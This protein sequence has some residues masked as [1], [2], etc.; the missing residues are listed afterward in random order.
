[1]LYSNKS[2]TQCLRWMATPLNLAFSYTSCNSLRSLPEASE[3]VLL[4]GLMKAFC[5]GEIGSF[6]GIGDAGSKVAGL[7]K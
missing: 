1:M 3:L 5:T 7:R 4:E 6:S 2:R